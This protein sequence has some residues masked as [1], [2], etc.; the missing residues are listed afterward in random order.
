MIDLLSQL[1]DLASYVDLFFVIGGLF[2]IDSTKTTS[3]SEDSRTGGTD[4]AVVAHK[5][6]IGEHPLS[7]NSGVNAAVSQSNINEGTVGGNR[8]GGTS[9]GQS[10]VNTGISLQGSKDSS[11]TLQNVDSDVITSF[12]H[13]LRD[14]LETQSSGLGDV[15]NRQNEA[16]TGLLSQIGDK[17][18]AL[19][20]SKQTEGDSGRNK[21]ILYVVG[22]VL[23]VIALAVFVFGRKR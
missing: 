7:V 9:G 1:A 12:G 20:E 13:T 15:L 3:T 19:A 17:I 18:S 11:F 16:S 22:G 5:G 23:L 6:A 4:Q 10:N 8:I 14:V 2:G 21:I